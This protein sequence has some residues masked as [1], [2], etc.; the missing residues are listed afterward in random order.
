MDRAQIHG[1]IGRFRRPFA[2]TFGA[3]F[4]KKQ[5]VKNGRF[6]GNFLA[7]LKID[8]FSPDLT[9]VFNVF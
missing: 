5:S 9:S 3:K 2:K 4:A 1:K 7:K 6:R 8:R